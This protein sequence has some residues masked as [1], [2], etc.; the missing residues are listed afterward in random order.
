MYEVMHGLMNAR[1]N[2]WMHE[3]INGRMDELMDEYTKAQMHEFNQWISIMDLKTSCV[4]D[5]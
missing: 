1:I 4:I 2:A 3:C 5:N